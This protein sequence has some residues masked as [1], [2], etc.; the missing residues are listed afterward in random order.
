ML[1]FENIRR[2][3]RASSLVGFALLTACGDCSGLNEPEVP[4]STK[5]SLGELVYRVI[6]NELRTDPECPAEYVASIER[7]HDDFVETFDYVIENGV[8]NDFPELLGGTIKPFIDNDKLPR[9]VD[10]LAATLAL[11]VDDE[12][13]PDRSTIQAFAN[14]SSTKSLLESSVAIQ[15][16]SAILIDDTIPD[17]IHT[18]ATI[19][20]EDDGVTYLMDD[21]MSLASYALSLDDT[22]STCSGLVTPDANTTLLRTD[23]F[24][25]NPAHAL[26]SPFYLARPDVNGN[27]VVI[28]DG[29]VLRGPFVD[30]DADGVADVNADLDPI[31]ANGDPIELAMIGED[32]ATGRDE[33]GRAIDANGNPIFDYYDVKRTA[34]SYTMQIGADLLATGIHHDV[35][36]VVSAALG[37]PVVCDEDEFCREYPSAQNIVADLA[38]MGFE[39]AEYGRVN[40]LMRTISDLLSADPAKSE[41]LLVA[42]GDIIRALDRSSLSM[43]DT[44]LTQAV[45]SL[46]PILANILATP[47]TASMPTARLLVDLFQDLGTTADEMPTELHYTLET[48]YDA[49]GQNQL[50]SVNY[51][52]PRFPQG[53]DDNRSGLEQVL[54]TFEYADCG[55]IGPEQPLQYPIRA[56]LWNALY[57]LD[58]Q[59]HPGTLA[60]VLVEFLSHQTPATVGNIAN[61]LDTLNGLLGGG[62]MASVLQ[63]G[64][65]CSA[66]DSQ[67]VAEHLPIFA[68]LAESG[69]LDWILPICKVFGDQGQTRVFID[70]LGTVAR[71]LRRDEDADPNTYS[72]FRRLGP[73]LLE[74]TE[75]PAGAP[76]NSTPFN[77]IFDVFDQLLA[78]PSADGDGTAADILIDSLAYATANRSLALRP[79]DGAASVMVNDSIAGRLLLS[80]EVLQT[81][82]LGAGAADELSRLVDGITPLLTTTT[83]SGAS[84]RLANPNLRALLSTLTS[85]VAMSTNLPTQDYLCYIR[86]GQSSSAEF[87]DS[88]HFATAIRVLAHLAS[89]PNAAALEDWI[90]SLLRGNEDRTIEVYGPVMQLA[91]GA[92]SSNASSDDMSEVLA[93]LGAGLDNQEGGGMREMVRTLDE[94]MVSDEERSI[95]TMVRSLFAPGPLDSRERPISTYARVAGNIAEIDPVNMCS[96]T[97]RAVD[98]TSIEDTVTS[99]TEFL[100][101]DA[102]DPGMTGIEQIWS[103]VGSLAPNE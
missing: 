77:K 9:L 47:N 101:R 98:A 51:D 60:A 74:M 65:N 19:A 29:G 78:I 28:A 79:I 71:E 36:A 2:A 81:R 102:S 53:G 23:G 76:A 11:L 93:W 89:S 30:A 44:T 21:M 103:L 58:N 59:I 6:R 14:L 54:E 12:F 27:P 68:Y 95:L 18:L 63:A 97:G 92:F 88:R 16:V 70:M 35:P 10:T 67:K 37:T 13:D 43:T 3:R 39:I 26:G 83:G 56:I 41:A 75:N 31:D 4:L 66:A 90:V 8:P 62:T 1:S 40:V 15:L 17:K 45:R 42:V 72:A 52:L 82:V 64:T 48:Q 84:R 85:V 5:P 50:E 87:M 61:L 46:V 99:L 24:V 33:F 100:E 25:E 96:A 38:W 20:Q 91:A 69:S 80:L 94:L 86:E 32:G 73:A 55:Y 49:Q 7:D 34:L 22:P 57:A